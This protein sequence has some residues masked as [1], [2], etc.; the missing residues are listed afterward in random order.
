MRDVAR[1]F[2]IRLLDAGA[3]LDQTPSFYYDHRCHFN[4][5]GHAVVA[6]LLLETIDG[7][8]LE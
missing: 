3:V 4:E 1:S 2:D 5:K 6:D 8:K 7:I